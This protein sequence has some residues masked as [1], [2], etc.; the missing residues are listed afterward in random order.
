MEESSGRKWTDKARKER[1]GEQNGE[2]RRGRALPNQVSSSISEIRTH[3]FEND[4][5]ASIFAWRKT[6]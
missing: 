3:D 5:M 1:A 6:N 2:D 4:I